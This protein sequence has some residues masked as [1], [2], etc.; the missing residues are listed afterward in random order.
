MR[1]FA[2][3]IAAFNGG[4]EV[5][6]QAARDSLRPILHVNPSK[7]SLWHHLNRLEPRRLVVATCVATSNGRSV[8]VRL[9]RPRSI[10]AIRG[11][12]F[13]EWADWLGVC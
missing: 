3:G 4:L 2:T 11:R 12:Q 7:A 8:P 6:S 1:G 10:D 9:A 5:V 13:S